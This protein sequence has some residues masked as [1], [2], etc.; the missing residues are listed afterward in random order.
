MRNSFRI[1]QCGRCHDSGAFSGL[2]LIWHRWSRGPPINSTK[3]NT[4]C[5]TIQCNNSTHF[6]PSSPPNT[7][8]PNATIQCNT[9]QCNT[10]HF[11]AKPLNAI[12]STKYNTIQCNN[13]MQHNAI[14]STKY[15]TIQCNS[16]M[17]HNTVEGKT[18]KCHTTR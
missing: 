1:V 9:I 13:S 4:N 10:T 5:I 14:K 16:S 11:K 15:N 12:K 2:E 6:K 8:K 18:F 7:I 3:Y 17:Q